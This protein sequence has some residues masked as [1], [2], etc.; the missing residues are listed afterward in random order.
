MRGAHAA[1]AHAARVHD[2]M[3]AHWRACASL[4][5]RAPHP[6]SVASCCGRD[7]P[8]A[9]PPSS[10]GGPAATAASTSAAAASSSAMDSSEVDMLAMMLGAS[11]AGCRSPH[12]AQGGAAT[13][14]AG[15]KRL[16]RT[17]PLCRMPLL[18]D[19]GCLVLEAPLRGAL[20][21]SS[22]YIFPPPPGNK[23]L[24]RT[25]PM[26]RLPRLPHL[27]RPGGPPCA[28]PRTS[29]AVKSAHLAKFH[30][31]TSSLHPMGTTSRRL[32]CR[33]LRCRLVT[34]CCAYKRLS[35]SLMWST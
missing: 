16:A 18:P 12:F 5:K 15:N 6:S 8:G 19:L 21:Q 23:R 28:A 13:L 22:S 4:C 9:P 27:P 33:R 26:P 29:R 17:P 2:A 3:A 14:N 20:N 32:S 24:A 34:S 35:T 31:R 25:P 7:G 1:R 10:C 30:N 11:S